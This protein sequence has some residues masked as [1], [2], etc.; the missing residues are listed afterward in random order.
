MHGERRIWEPLP[1]WYVN[2]PES[3]ESHSIY[4]P[5]MYDLTGLPALEACIFL[6]MATFAETPS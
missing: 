6:N 4:V 2:P 5:V 1:I 3:A